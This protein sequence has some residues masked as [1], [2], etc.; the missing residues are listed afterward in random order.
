[1][2]VADEV[3]AATEPLVHE[4]TEEH[5]PTLPARSAHFLEVMALPSDD[6]AHGS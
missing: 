2:L 4:L 1:V 6:D 3:G 5:V